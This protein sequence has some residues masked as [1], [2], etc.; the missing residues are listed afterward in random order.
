[1]LYI[2]VDQCSRPV[3]VSKPACFDFYAHF[4]VGWSLKH[5]QHW[6]QAV[7]LPC[8]LRAAAEYSPW[9]RWT[10]FL[11]KLVAHSIML[12]CYT[13][14]IDLTVSFD[15]WAVFLLEMRRRGKRNVAAVG[16]TSFK[17]G[18]MVFSHPSKGV[19]WC[20]RMPFNGGWMEK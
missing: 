8:T 17:R 9:R 18:T 4:A 5:I 14:L 16:P 19:R 13:L 12:Y 15:C 6:N 7:Y 10:G 2:Q 11:R 20:F 3:V 1:M